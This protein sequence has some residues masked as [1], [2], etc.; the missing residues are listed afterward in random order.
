MLVLAL[1]EVVV[2]APGGEEGVVRAAFDDPAVIDDQEL[3]GLTDRAQAVGD[4]KGGTAVH[5]AQQPLL[6][7]LLGAR[8]HAAGGLVE[9]EDA[10]VGQDG[11]GDG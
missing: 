11:A 8:V 10:R 7:L 4:D 6:D 1:V 3:V 5:E 2:E 9:D